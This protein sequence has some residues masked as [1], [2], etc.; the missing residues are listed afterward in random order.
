L[1]KNGHWVGGKK[2]EDHCLPTLFY[3]VTPKEKGQTKTQRRSLFEE[4]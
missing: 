4:E 3:G 1:K 2:R